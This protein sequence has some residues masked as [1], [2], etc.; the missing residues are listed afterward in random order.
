V[1]SWVTKLHA[2]HA[3]GTTIAAFNLLKRIVKHTKANATFLDDVTL[4][5]RSHGEAQFL[6][7][8]QIA[9]L[10]DAVP[11]RYRALV[12]TGAIAGLRWGELV[13]LKV[14]RL[15]LLARPPTIQVAE[16][17]TEVS[18]RFSIARRRPGRAAARSPSRPSSRRSLPATSP[19]FPL[20]FM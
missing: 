14:Q 13:G 1:Q 2:S 8:E 19:P 16:Q 10:A 12:L 9:T 4:P 6:T 11:A 20:M 15:N 7:P 3:A 17:L 5:E 18:G